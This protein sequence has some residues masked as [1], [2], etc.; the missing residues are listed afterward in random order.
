[1]TPFLQTGDPVPKF[2]P[3][4]Y[5]LRFSISFLWLMKGGMREFAPTH[6][7]HGI[8]LKVHV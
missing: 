8:V 7:N 5:F 4:R 3:L 1:M 6:A 2:K